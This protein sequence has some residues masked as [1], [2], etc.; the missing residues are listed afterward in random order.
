MATRWSAASSSGGRWSSTATAPRCG[1][2]PSKGRCTWPAAAD[3]P[4]TARGFARARPDLPPLPREILTMHPRILLATVSLS[5]LPALA[6]G[7]P[8]GEGDELRRGDEQILKQAG[9][10][11]DPAT[12]LAPV[13]DRTPS[14]AEEEEEARLIRQLG[15][16]AYAV[17]VK[18]SAR[19]V[20]IGV[21]AR[22]PLRRA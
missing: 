7:A 22:G 9:H 4:V 20:E 1:R 10:K 19:L 21:K 12:L 17:R 18:A 2:T 13:A 14:A 15:D 5:L 3:R 11:A 8:A 16:P 6:G